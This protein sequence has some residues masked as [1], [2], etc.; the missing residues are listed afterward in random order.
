MLINAEII[1]MLEA[2]GEGED[3]DWNYWESVDVVGEDV[4]M[5]KFD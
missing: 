2:K 5:V 1:G 4:G 3:G